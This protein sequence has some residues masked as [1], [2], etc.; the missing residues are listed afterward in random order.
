MD[1]TT[2]SK[3]AFDLALA[4]ADR[5]QTY[6]YAL[7]GVVFAL[8][9]FIG[10]KMMALTERVVTAVNTNTAALDALKERLDGHK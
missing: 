3:E 9:G 2:V 1:P 7:G 4:N 10:V 8:G 5:L 6:L